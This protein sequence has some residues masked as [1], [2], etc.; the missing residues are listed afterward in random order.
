M[1]VET[2]AATESAARTGDPILRLKAVD[3]FFGDFAA[4]DRVSLDIHEG[5]FFTIV[6]PS[7]SGKTT[8]VRMLVG[9]DKPTNGDILLRGERINDVP[10]NR[11]PTCM[12]FQSLA[13]FPH[14]TV[15]QNIEFPLKIR[16]VAPAERKARALELMAQLRL[17]DS[18]YGKGVLQCSGGERQRVALARALAFDPD[19]LFFDEPLSA[20]DYK[21]RK[22]LEKE[23]KDIHRETG[24]TFVYI[25]HSLEEAMV[26][27]DRIGVMNKGRFV[28]IGTP[29]Q[30]YAN[31]VNRFVSE[32]MGEVNV[33][34][35][36]RGAAGSLVDRLTGAAYQSPAG[37]SEF[38][39][40]ALVVRPEDIRF[41]DH[42]DDAADNK[43][44]GTIYNDYLLG[45]RVQYQVRVGSSQIFLVEKLR[46]QQ[47]DVA[48]GATVTIAWDT[49]QS[50]L[51]ATPSFTQS[52]V[53]R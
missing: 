25:T 51:F 40:A 39:E 49:R 10:A 31:P 37:D 23:L 43:L 44:T 11:R 22:L 21:L 14:R 7:G 2:A 52:M 34:D 19:I 1:I 42:P 32:F 30:I 18:Y 15:G 26:M 13:L 38:R 28:Q 12:V 3:K 5:E 45:S 48:R 47:L 29:N 27:S 41:L 6:G 33:V 50:M 35:V 17:P 16:G 8:M 46:E 20:L 53:A 24:K 4:V 9:M 36:E